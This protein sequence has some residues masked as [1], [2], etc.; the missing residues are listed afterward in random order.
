MLAMPDTNP[1]RAGQTRCQARL[2]N[3]DAPDAEVACEA[4]AGVEL[5]D[6]QLLWVDLVNP[7]EAMLDQAWQ[8]CELPDA[9]RAFL[10]AG[11]SPEVQKEAKWFWL[12][13]VAVVDSGLDDIKGTVLS[14]IANGHVVV[15][16]HQ[17]EIEFIET[18]RAREDR[19]SSIG[20][21]STDSFVASLLDWQ[22]STYFDAV[23]DFELGVE[24]LE[25]EILTERARQSLPELQ[26]LR[27]AAS[28]LRRMLAP[29]RNV[30]GALSRPDFRPDESRE[31]ERH[32][33]ALD[34]RF[35]R[36]MD[37]VENARDL[38][39]GSFEL[40]SNQTA[41]EV[42]R[43]MKILTFATVV[44]GL[45]ATIAGTLGMN[46]DASFFK[47]RDAGFWIAVGGMATLGI[48]SLAIGR[49]F[50]WL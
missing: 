42:N 37:M 40:F 12:R 2:F 5:S 14:I 11:T 38:V 24:R 25:V 16:I 46:F 44:I 32:F 18:L 8:G 17:Q 20:Q 48:A 50:K 39:I 28:R 23:A 30:F 34:T 41:L 7:D 9:A 29:H 47:A 33:G 13:V 21:M 27:K 49:W 15:S 4:L 3:A 43:S 45:L 31:A 19:H 10:D 26:R 35:E 6:D 36:A 1:P 22:L